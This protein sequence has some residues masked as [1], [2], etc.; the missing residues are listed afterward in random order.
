MARRCRCVR[1][2]SRAATIPGIGNCWSFSALRLAVRIP[3][4]AKGG[5]TQSHQNAT[6][7]FQLSGICSIVTM[8]LSLIDY[9]LWFS[10]PTMQLCVLVAMYKRG[11]HHDYPYFFS[12]TILQV[13][14][15]PI[16]FLLHRQSYAAYWVGYWVS[17]AL[18]ALIS[19]AVLQEIFKNAFRPYEAL[20]DLSVILFRWSALVI[21]LVAGMW[22]ITSRADQ[23]D[24]VKNTIFLASRSVR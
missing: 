4:R 14:G 15:E 12:Y 3:I 6:C 24:A 10:A 1:R 20:R 9:V 17:I 16:L 11:L 21:L 7:L 19:F 13:A 18:S 23:G 22:A 5:L 2:G 8:H